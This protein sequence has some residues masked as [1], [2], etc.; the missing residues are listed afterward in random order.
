MSITTRRRGRVLEVTLDRPDARNAFDGETI[1]ALTDVFDG[2]T[3]AEPATA[4]LTEAE[5]A[6]C[7]PHAV[8]LRAEGPVFCAGGDLGD[9]KRLGAADFE[10]NLEAAR[11][12]GAMF[13]T[14]RNCAAPVVARVQGPAYG[15][16]VGLVSSCDVVVASVESRFTFSEVRLGLVAGVIAPVVIGKIGPA[17][18]RHWFLTGECIDSAEALRIGLADRLCGSRQLDGTVSEV[19]GALLRGGPEALSRIKSLVEGCLTLGFERSLDFSARMIAEA[20][21]SGEAQLA[22]QAFFAKQTPPW[23]VTDPWPPDDEGER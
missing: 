10:T 14:I 8:L 13:R 3:A 2:V 16:G 7:R 20:R 4:G 21:T 15:G 9:M 23:A 5:A 11:R 12:M 17:A 19:M 1:E 22:L 18:A 6:H